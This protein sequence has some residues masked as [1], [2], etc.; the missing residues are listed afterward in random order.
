[1]SLP[2][3]ALPKQSA[4]C[5]LSAVLVGVAPLELSL[6]P[7]PQGR[8]C[9]KPAKMFWRLSVGAASRR[10]ACTAA[11]GTPYTACCPTSRP[12]VPQV[13]LG[14]GM[15][16]DAIIADR[17]FNTREST[18]AFLGWQAVDDVEYDPR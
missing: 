7:A 12:P 16:R 13:N 10:I 3:T 18:N 2:L 17:A 8:A 15:P 11:C 6:P 5:G 14:L 1:M 4:W 9:S